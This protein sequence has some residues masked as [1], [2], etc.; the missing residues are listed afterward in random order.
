MCVRCGTGAIAWCTDPYR[1]GE[2]AEPVSPGDPPV[3][4]ETTGTFYLLTCRECGNGDLVM[5]FGSEEERS[6][7]AGAHTRGTGYDRWHVTDTDALEAA[8]ARAEREDPA[9]TEL[10][11][12]AADLLELHFAGALRG[13]RAI[14]AER[15][16][17]VR[18]EPVKGIDGRVFQAAMLAE[19]IDREASR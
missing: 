19:E 16:R 5:P 2:S 10:R 9:L 18:G 15:L 3:V 8:A 11:V 14:V 12:L 17:Q 7:W 1:H 13:V 6:R 4:T